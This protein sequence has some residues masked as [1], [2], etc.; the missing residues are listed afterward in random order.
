MRRTLLLS[1]AFVLGLGLVLGLAEPASSA[2]FSGPTGGALVVERPLEAR[3]R[4]PA[5]KFKMGAS[6]EAA[7]AALGLCREELGRQA[8]QDCDF[9]NEGPE[10]EVYLSAYAIDRVE[11]TVADYRACARA[12]ACSPAPLFG[13][14]PRL[15]APNLPVTR[16]SWDEAAAYCRF[17]GARL[18]TEAEWERAARGQD[19]RTFPWGNIPNPKL[20]NHGRFRTVGELGPQPLTVVE[21]DPSDGYAFLSKVGAFPAGASPDGVLDLAG[22][23]MEWTA[24]VYAPDPPEKA[25]PVNPRGPEDGPLRSVRG[26]S[27]RQPLLYQRTTSRNGFPPSFRSPELGFRC[28]K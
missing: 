16:V 6:D 11:V 20:C 5:G 9:S 27:F 12:G 1:V 23:V 4:I 8:M 17:R 18:P 13:G 2:T 19:G 7:R 25:S 22:N 15:S 21:V 10:R 26:G 3:I 14:D 24:D 28:V